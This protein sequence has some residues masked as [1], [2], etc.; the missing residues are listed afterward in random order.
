MGALLAF[1]LIECHVLTVAEHIPCE[2]VAG[3]RFVDG[4]RISY[5]AKQSAGRITDE[6]HVLAADACGVVGALKHNDFLEAEEL[7]ENLLVD[8]RRV[9]GAAGVLHALDDVAV[10]LQ[11]VEGIHAE[12]ELVRSSAAGELDVLLTCVEEVHG[13]EVGVSK[14]EEFLLAVGCAVSNT[15]PLICPYA[16]LEEVVREEDVLMEEHLLCCE[17]NLR[18]ARIGYARSVSSLEVESCDLVDA[19]DDLID[20]A[21]VG[22]VGLTHDGRLNLTEGRLAAH[23]VA[24]E[25]CL[26]E[27]VVVAGALRNGADREDLRCDKVS[28]VGEMRH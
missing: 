15:R 27:F 18:A 10:V 5:V 28:G 7:G 22:V 4:R 24:S 11:C 26:A 17:A 21:L 1:V 20:F 14:L 9:C 6:F 8:S 3:R 23:V 25:V 12:A 16:S 19:H 2:D 13:I